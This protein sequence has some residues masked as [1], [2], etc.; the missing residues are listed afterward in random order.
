MG[1]FPPAPSL[2]HFYYGYVENI[3]NFFFRL[4]LTPC[5]FETTLNGVGGMVAMVAFNFVYTNELFIQTKRGGGVAPTSRLIT[6]PF[7]QATRS[8][9]V[10]RRDRN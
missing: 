5:L 7:R 10:A 1:T 6:I 9:P 3:R 4:E 8:S 2:S